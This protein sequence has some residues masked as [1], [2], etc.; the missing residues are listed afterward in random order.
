MHVYG[1][2]Y[3]EDIVVDRLSCTILDSA[4]K[5]LMSAFILSML[6]PLAI[7][8]IYSNLLVQDQRMKG[9]K[10]RIKFLK[11]PFRE[12]RGVGEEDM[13]D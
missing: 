13:M 9:A 7:D 2:F 4:M 3:M 5:C 12:E 8:E 1:L 11:S 10:K 6:A